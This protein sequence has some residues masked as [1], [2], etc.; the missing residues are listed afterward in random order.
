MC[1]ISNLSS[2]YM[3]IRNIKPSAIFCSCIAKVVAAT[4]EISSLQPSSVA[5]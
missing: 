1:E 5:A 4:S 3:Y 2:F